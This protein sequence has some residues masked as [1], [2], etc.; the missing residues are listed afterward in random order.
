MHCICE[1]NKDLSTVCVSPDTVVFTLCRINPVIST[2]G[3]RCD[4]SASCTSMLPSP[5]VVALINDPTQTHT[6]SLH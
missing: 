1:N 5:E 6:I 3:Q 4:C 2:T